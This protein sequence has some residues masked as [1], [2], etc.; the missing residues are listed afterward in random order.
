MKT[1][2][3]VPQWLFILPLALALLGVFGLP[4]TG[5]V[6][7]D[8]GQGTVA[9][10]NGSTYYTG[11]LNHIWGTPIWLCVCEP[12]YLNCGPQCF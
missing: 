12:K 4:F 2:R 3:K 7:T 6:G 5:E 1:L 8:L 11:Q 10:A 9:L